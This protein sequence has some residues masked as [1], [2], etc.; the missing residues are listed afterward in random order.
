MPRTEGAMLEHCCC[1]IGS[2]RAAEEANS[3]R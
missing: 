1:R 2:R 3:I